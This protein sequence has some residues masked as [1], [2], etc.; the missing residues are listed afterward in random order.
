MYVKGVSE[1]ITRRG[2]ARS[3]SSS[4]KTDR[5]PLLKV[6]FSCQALDLAVPISAAPVLP[7][8]PVRVGLATCRS[9]A[10]W[11]G[12]RRSVRDHTPVRCLGAGHDPARG[13]WSRELRRRRHRLSWTLSSGGQVQGNTPSRLHLGGGR[14]VFGT[15][16]AH[17]REGKGQPPPRSRSG[18]SDERS[19]CLGEA[20]GSLHQNGE[21]VKSVLAG[22]VLFFL[23]FLSLAHRVDVHGPSP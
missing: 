18:G 5:H 23:F 15:V 10:C 21:L 1:V 13:F 4:R 11:P 17:G 6:R 20:R 2:C 3:S 9:S 7:R 14:L 8:S 22:G 12:R 19:R 16:V